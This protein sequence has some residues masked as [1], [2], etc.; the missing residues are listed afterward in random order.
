MKPK[1]YGKDISSVNTPVKFHLPDGSTQLFNN[2]QEAQAWFDENYSD[3]YSMTEYIP[4]QGD[5]D[6]PIQLPEITVTTQAPKKSLSSSP[7]R[8]GVDMQVGANYSPRFSKYFYGTSDFGALFGESRVE[9][10][11]KAWQRNPEYMQKAWTNTGNEIGTVASLP[12]IGGLYGASPVFAEAMNLTGAYQGLGRL[13]SEEG[14]TKTVNKVQEGDWGGAT[15]SFGGDVLDITMSLPFL[16]R[17]RQLA[18]Q[19]YGTLL[20]SS[21]IYRK[22]PFRDNAYYRVLGDSHGD[23]AS[24]AIADAEGVGVIRS[25]PKGSW[26]A[27]GDREHFIGPYFSKGKPWGSV[28]KEGKVIVGE[29]DIPGTSWMEINPHATELVEAP[30]STQFTPVYNGVPNSTPTKYFHYFERGSGPISKHFWFRRNFKPQVDPTLPSQSRFR[31]GGIPKMKDLLVTKQPLWFANK[32]ARPIKVDD[33]G[34]RIPLFE[35]QLTPENTSAYR[36]EDG[37]GFRRFPQQSVIQF[38]IFT[39]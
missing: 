1:N 29:F 30:G 25:N 18:E 15:K 21:N 28:P 39:K 17:V 8:G 38:P 36:W 9:G 6:H 26:V 10:V 11:K 12:I 31:V 27:N 3:G 5:S 35:E 14:I 2:S 33:G 4:T 20:A 19:G 7:T 23:L 13:T 32:N 37:Y 22:I 24:N 16:N 34:R